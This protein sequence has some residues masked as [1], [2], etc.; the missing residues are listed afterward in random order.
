VRLGAVASVC[1]TEAVTTVYNLRV[2]DHHTYFVGGS[3]WGWDVWVHNAYTGPKT[4]NR[5]GHNRTIRQTAREVTASGDTVLAGGRSFDGVYRKEAVFETLG[6]FKGSRR[7]DLLVQR[8]DGSIYGINVGRSQS[9]GQPVLRERLAIQD[10][11]E[12]RGLE[13]QFVSYGRRS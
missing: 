3:D 2:A 8:P 10:L 12:I 13:M 7:P 11:N 4:D 9:N 1:S 6:G 5:F